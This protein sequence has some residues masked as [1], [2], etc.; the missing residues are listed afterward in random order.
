[1]RDWF[2]RRIAG[3]A[4]LDR[5]HFLD[6]IRQ[7]DLVALYQ[8]C[9]VFVL[10]SL[11]DVYPNAVLEAMA[12]ARPCVVSNTV[13]V[14][15][16]VQESSCGTVVPAGDASAL[17]HALSEILALPVHIR[18][19]MGIRGRRIVER[20]CSRDFIARQTVEAYREVV[21]AHSPVRRPGDQAAMQK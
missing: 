2:T 15:E 4:A 21:A 19:E 11:N 14:A 10:P 17:A 6:P 8:S 9:A 16:L 13:G 5:V 3:T 20:T 18:E 7:R 1:M 12:C